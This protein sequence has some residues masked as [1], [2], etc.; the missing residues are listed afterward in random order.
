MVRPAL[1]GQG[2]T[3]LMHSQAPTARVAGLACAPL[4]AAA[5]VVLLLAGCLGSPSASEHPLANGRDADAV[6]FRSTMIAPNKY[7]KEPGLAF[8]PNGDLFVCATRGLGFGAALWRSLDGG[9]TFESTGTE[10]P[11]PP[12]VVGPVAIPYGPVL[13]GASVGGGDCDV[14]VD[15]KGTVYLADLS[16]AGISVA[17]SSDRGATWQGVPVTLLGSGFDRPWLVAGG[18]RE[19]TLAAT[20]ISPANVQGLDQYKEYLGST[21][22]IL[23]GRSTDGGITFPAQSK[24]VSG[25][26]SSPPNGN[27]AAG[28]GELYVAYPRIMSG[29]RV[30]IMVAT[31]GDKGMNWKQHQVAVQSS[32]ENTCLS[33]LMVFPIVAADESG[34]V[35]LA[36]VLKNRETSRQDLF[37]ASSTDRGETWSPPT[38]ITPR[39][40]TRLFPWI[41]AGSSGRAG[42]VWYESPATS[43]YNFTDDQLGSL[44]A[45]CTLTIPENATWWLHY[46]YAD[47]ALSPSPHF[48]DV[49]VQPQP[50]SD[51]N[52]SVGEFPQVKFD[53]KGNAGI[54]YIAQSESG[55]RAPVFALQQRGPL[56]RAE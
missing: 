52:L 43:M 51:A 10:V 41:A 24:A 1:W 23:V 56:G 53:A 38:L 48:V 50:V 28:A 34:G 31:S 26:E 4:A 27:L 29:G 14:A 15:S 35:Y 40:G 32:F 55:E 47:N 3:R 16:V 36:W 5:L 7:A 45:T 54:T 12:I 39:P 42:I 13:R 18:P 11:V 2:A 46:A 37:F 19:V 20:M 44:G 6:S 17:S 33:P 49:L 8:A 22:G 21:G 25:N 9:L 30:A